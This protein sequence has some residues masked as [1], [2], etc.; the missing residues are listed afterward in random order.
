[1]II[2]ESEMN[3]GDFDDDSLFYIERSNLYQKLGPDF[4]TVKLVIKDVKHGIIFLEAKKSCPNKVNCNKSSESKTKF[5]EYYSSVAEKFITSF[6]IYLAAILGV[7]ENN[8]EIGEKLR[9]KNSSL[10][11]MELKFVLVIKDAADEEWLA[12]PRQELNS[13][14][15]QIQ[16]IWKIKVLVLNE[17]LAQKYHLVCSEQA[18]G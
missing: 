16:K 12:G 11:D 18:A 10:K 6:Q 7:H 14:L 1:M 3:F 8:M 9:I 2:H 4:K 5:E 17:S 13:R 15:R